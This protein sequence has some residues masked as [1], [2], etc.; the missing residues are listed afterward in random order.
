MREPEIAQLHD[1]ASELNGH[2]IGKGNIGYHGWS[3]FAND[4]S[5]RVVVRDHDGSVKHFATGAVIGVVMA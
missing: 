1:F 4:V 5:L 3:L 2:T